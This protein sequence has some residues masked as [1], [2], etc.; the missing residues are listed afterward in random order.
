MQIQKNEVVNYLGYKSKEDLN[1][2]LTFI[3]LGIATKNY[4][5]LKCYTEFTHRDLTD[6]INLLF[7]ELVNLE[8]WNTKKDEINIKTRSELYKLFDLKVLKQVPLKKKGTYSIRA[9]DRANEL[10]LHLNWQFQN[11]SYKN[12]LK[13]TFYNTK[14]L[15]Q[16]DDYKIEINFKNINGSLNI[17]YE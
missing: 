8:G 13:N 6:K 1:Y 14:I 5:K 12:S 17:E 4:F 9:T 3:I 7:P 15:K 10:L 11:S 2:P 16:D